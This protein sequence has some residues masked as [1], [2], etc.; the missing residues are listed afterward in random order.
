[1]ESVFDEVRTRVLSDVRRSSGI[2]RYR[3]PAAVAAC[4]ALLV[5]ISFYRTPQ[6]D[7]P[8]RAMPRPAKIKEQLADNASKPM[9]VEP[10]QQK[11]VRAKT[12][13]RLSRN[14]G[15]TAK[16]PAPISDSE[17]ISEV[18]SLFEEKAPAA[19]EGPVVI[20]MQT[21]DPDVTIILLTD[22]T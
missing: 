4:V 14:T 19:L 3:W 17:L 15:R 11:P 12:P 10:V 21:Q 22:S 16:S 1:P 13:Q 18:E 20:T 2:R 8:E 6:I 9:Q 7:L 5:L